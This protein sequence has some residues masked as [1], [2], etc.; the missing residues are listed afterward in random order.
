MIIASV[1]TSEIAKALCNME[2]FTQCAFSTNVLVQYAEKS[3]PQMKTI[4]KKNATVQLMMTQS[5]DKVIQLNTGAVLLVK[6]RRYRRMKLAFTRP[7]A[8]T[9]K[10]STGQN[11]YQVKICSSTRDSDCGVILYSRL[12]FPLLYLGLAPDI[13]AP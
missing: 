7:S 4:E 5:M 1:T 2:V 3:F 10:I 11:A 13:L 12:A 6:I 8:G 9:C